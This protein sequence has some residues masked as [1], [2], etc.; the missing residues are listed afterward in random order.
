MLEKFECNG[1]GACCSQLHLFGPQYAHL[2]DG[3]GVC[4]YYDDTTHLCRVY[5][6]RPLVC[7]VEEGYHIYFKHIPYAEYLKYTRLGCDVLRSNLAG[8]KKI[9]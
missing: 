8:G 3:H 9:E 1:C 7:R 5:A 2:D 4:R 6:I